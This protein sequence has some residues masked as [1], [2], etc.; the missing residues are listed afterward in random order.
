MPNGAGVLAEQPQAVDELHEA[1]V[2][3]PQV[4]VSVQQ[5]SVANF[6]VPLPDKFSFKPKEWLEWIKRF[7]KLTGLNQ[8]DSETQVNSLIYS[9]GDGIAVLLGLTAE[10]AEEYN[11]VK[12]K[13][14]RHFVIKRN[15]IFE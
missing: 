12:E 2:A 7:Q 9:M 11:T 1:G 10:E 6:Q 15:T 13:F 4:A 3:Q 14:E 8:K 5:I